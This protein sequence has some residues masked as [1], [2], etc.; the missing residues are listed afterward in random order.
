MTTGSLSSQV[1]SFVWSHLTNLMESSDPVNKYVQKLL[2][3]EVLEKE[4]DLEKLKFSRNYEGSFYLDKY[5]TGAKV[6]HRHFARKIIISKQFRKFIVTSLK[7]TVVYF[8]YKKM[9]LMMSLTVKKEQNLYKNSSTTFNYNKTFPF[10]CY[11]LIY[12]QNIQN[13][14]RGS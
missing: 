10:L 2:N 12:C 1:G 13:K 8:I 4:F 9:Y 3:D 6:A 14:I 7:I 5:N 11:L